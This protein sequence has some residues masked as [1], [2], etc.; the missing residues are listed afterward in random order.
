M[1]Q[2]R[3]RAAVP[4]PQTTR[5]THDRLLPDLRRGGLL[6]RLRIGRVAELVDEMAPGDLARQAFGD[7]AIVLGM[8]LLT[9]DRVIT[10]SAP[11][12]LR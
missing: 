10:T 9:S 5:A 6:V 8:T 4:A 3:K 7:V 2:P 12:A 11:I 1:R